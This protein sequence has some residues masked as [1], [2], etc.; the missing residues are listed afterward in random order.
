MTAASTSDARK[1]RIVTADPVEVVAQA[2]Y[3]EMPTWS[4]SMQRNFRWAE[5][6]PMRRGQLQDWALDIVTALRAEGL[7]A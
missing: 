7:L 3:A 2:L 1:R 4:Y 5:I 6:E